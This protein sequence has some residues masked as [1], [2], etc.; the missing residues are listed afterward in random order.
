MEQSSPEG[1]IVKAATG[2]GYLL[3]HRVGHS[4]YLR[5]C[6]YL[7]LIVRLLLRMS[8]EITGLL[9]LFSTAGKSTPKGKKSGGVVRDKNKVEFGWQSVLHAS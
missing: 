4:N 8:W 6:L 5:L 1:K 7:K 9:Q 2:R 3:L